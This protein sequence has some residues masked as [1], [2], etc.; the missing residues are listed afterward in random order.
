MLFFGMIVKGEESFRLK[1]WIADLKYGRTNE[2]KYNHRKKCTSIKTKNTRY[3]FG[4]SSITYERLVKS[5]SMEIM[6]PN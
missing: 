3:R 5:Q 1:K 6:E 2:I 4:I